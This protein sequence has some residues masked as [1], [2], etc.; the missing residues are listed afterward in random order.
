MI[1]IM[2]RIKTEELN[3]FEK[4]PIYLTIDELCAVLNVGKS[5]AYNYVRSGLI[6]SIRIGKQIRIPKAGL[7]DIAVQS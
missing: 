7:K 2:I 3:D 6:Y 4:L 5:S 1:A